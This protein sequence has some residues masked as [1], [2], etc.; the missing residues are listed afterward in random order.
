MQLFCVTVMWLQHGY[1]KVTESLN[2]D[3]RWQQQYVCY[4]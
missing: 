4:W 3:V 1:A 2:A